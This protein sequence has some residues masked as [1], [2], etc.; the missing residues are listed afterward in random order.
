MNRPCAAA[1]VTTAVATDVPD[2]VVD[3]Q[4]LLTVAFPVPLDCAEIVLSP[5]AM[6]SGFMR[7][8]GCMPPALNGDT[9]VPEELSE[10]TVRA[11]LEIAGE[12]TKPGPLLPAATTTKVSLCSYMNESISD[13]AAVYCKI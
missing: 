2:L 1:A 8:S 12:V 6:R 9:L 13:A 10:P 7:P 4:W 11:F 3:A 5:M